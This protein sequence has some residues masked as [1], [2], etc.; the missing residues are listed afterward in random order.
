MIEEG[1]CHMIVF[2][3]DSMHA[4]QDDSTSSCSS[5]DMSFTI[6]WINSPGVKH[7]NNCFWRPSLSASGQSYFVNRDNYPDAA[8]INHLR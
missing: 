5:V 8:L 1:C 7:I 4:R 2:T 3:L 6:R